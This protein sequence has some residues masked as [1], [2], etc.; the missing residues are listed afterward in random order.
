VRTVIDIGRQ[1]C[2][3]IEVEAGMARD[4]QMNDKC[5]AGS[6]R[7]LELIRTRLDADS[8]VMEELLAAGRRVNLNSN[9]L[10]FAESEVIGLLARGVSRE[11]I[12]GGAAASLAAR[13]FRC[14]E[15]K[16]FSPEVIGD[17][18]SILDLRTRTDGNRRVN[19][20]V[21]I[22]NLGNMDRSSLFYRGR[23]Y[24]KSPDGRGRCQV[25]TL[26]ANRRR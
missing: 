8:A 6:G 9:C 15:D 12:L 22:R 5:A 21:Q 1:D 10:V 24:S 19:I 18:S 17:K 7:F 26:F 4:F 13:I 14:L 2:K 23:E 16:T 25:S 3:V 11:E 20:E